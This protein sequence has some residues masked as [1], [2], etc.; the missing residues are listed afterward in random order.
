MKIDD[1][2]TL[3]TLDTEHT[4]VHKHT[5]TFRDMIS[6]EEITQIFFLSES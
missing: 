4:R 6:L 2:P 3:S 5:H 1:P